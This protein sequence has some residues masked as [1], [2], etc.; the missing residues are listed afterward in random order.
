[1][2]ENATMKMKEWERKKNKATHG[3]MRQWN[4]KK[5]KKEESNIW[6]NETM[7]IKERERIK[8]HM[9]EWDNERMK[10][11]KESDTW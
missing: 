4:R 11:K 8:Q 7:E 9:R 1:M 5:E 2:Q 3:R 10:N 6:V